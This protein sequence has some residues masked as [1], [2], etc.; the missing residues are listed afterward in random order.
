M[1]TQA[2]LPRTGFESQ[3]RNN[4]FSIKPY[5]NNL[6]TPGA[7]YW[8][9][10]IHLV[11]LVMATS[12]AIAWGYLG[13]LFGKATL[14]YIAAAITFVFMFLI[15]WVID[16]SF[17]TLDLSRSYYDKIILK[18]ETDRWVDNTRLGIGMLGRVAIVFVSLSISAP[19]LAQIV[20]KQDIDNEINRRN[21]ATVSMVSD[22]MMIAKD[23]EIAAVDSMIL[24][25]EAELIQETAGNGSS[26]N[27]GFGP[28][29]RAMQQNINRLQDERA[30]L[31]Q[32]KA[33]MAQT[34]QSLTV[35]EFADV[36]NVD[37]VDDGVRTREA[38]LAG[39]MEN[40]EYQTAKTAIT[41]FLAFIFAALV[42]LKL[43]QPRS[44]R[45]YYNEKLQDL[46]REYLAGH[47][48]KWIA[49]PEQSVNGQTQMSPLRFEDWCV[50]TYS[51]V[52]NED[53]KR[54]DSRKIYN[55]FKMKIEQLEEE[56]AELKRMMDPVEQDYEQAMNEVN[57][58]KIELLEVENELEFNERDGT[59]I[60]RQLENISDD[61]RQNRFQG[62]DVLIA[63]TAKKEAEAKLASNKNERLALQYKHD[64]IRHRFD[65]KDADAKQVE[66]LMSKVRMHYRD[67]QEKIDRE[68]IAYTDLVV[69]GHVVD[70]PR[71]PVFA[72]TIGNEQLP[73]GEDVPALEHAAPPVLAAAALTGA[74]VVAANER[75]EEV[76]EEVNPVENLLSD[77][78][79]EA[80]VDE[81]LAP[82]ATPYNEAAI[83]PAVSDDE[84]MFAEEAP[85]SEFSSA[86][87]IPETQD[88][89]LPW[90]DEADDASVQ[91]MDERPEVEEADTIDLL[92][93]ADAYVLAD[94]DENTPDALESEDNQSED[95]EDEV[96]MYWGYD[97]DEAD[98]PDADEALA[99]ER[100][101]LAEEEALEDA[102]E[103]R[104]LLDEQPDQRAL[105]AEEQTDLFDAIRKKEEAKDADSPIEFVD[106]HELK[107]YADAAALAAF[108]SE[109]AKPEPHPEDAPAPAEQ[110][111]TDGQEADETAPEPQVVA[112]YFVDPALM[113][114][115]EL[116]ADKQ[117]ES[118]NGESDHEE[119][120]EF[121]PADEL[122]ATEFDAADELA[123]DDSAEGAG[124]DTDAL[125]TA[126]VFI[127]DEPA[128]DEEAPIDQSAGEEADLP[129]IYIHR[130]ALAEDV[131]EEDVPD[132]EVLDEEMIDEDDRLVDEI[133]E[134]M[135]NRNN[136]ADRNG[137]PIR[138]GTFGK[139]F[140]K[141][142]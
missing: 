102:E 44:V 9:I 77:R 107:A 70:I 17:V 125:A 73:S 84:T 122:V 108:A 129:T 104:A 63:V 123:D 36:Y 140:G 88:S 69:S 15:I 54:R 46:Y 82:E 38:V 97:D 103:V 27:Y 29:T 25:R 141:G 136:R 117:D 99:W 13:S 95:T 21:M 75:E 109:E 43:F 127:E 113:T 128:V 67:L 34:V 114:Y 79:A 112:D 120:A 78:T 130:D 18:K 139:T 24:V 14:G 94:A 96:N 124:A 56:K 60:A 51:V 10:C 62:S 39:L 19:F 131:I 90:E 22:S 66:S 45:I 115:N 20:F 121:E 119:E 80:A 8:I 50:N 111:A 65:V 16:V 3:G 81:L 2:A 74:A 47:L 1:E 91:L 105:N 59:E 61:L 86:T 64:L 89:V 98:S 52:R 57:A 92:D 42:L 72:D 53:I 100:D 83:H 30:T 85:V 12:E 110:S 48:N 58:V 49:E 142:V 11:I 126:E 135:I 41:A 116:L 23:E 6:L 37:L 101:M 138:K 106:D 35:D 93:E 87:E 7:N 118:F 5:K 132:E 32:D 55:L 133:I 33:V 71:Q 26:G 68:R 28:V 134:Q 40:Q 137:R 4:L 76:S 31:L